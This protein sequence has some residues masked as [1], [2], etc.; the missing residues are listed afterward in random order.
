MNGQTDKWKETEGKKNRH[1]DRHESSLKQRDRTMIDRV[2]H[3]PVRV[4]VLNMIPGS[5]RDLGTALLRWQP[6]LSPKD[7]KLDN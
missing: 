1:T 7:L 5:V 4:V 2:T 6:L 3:F